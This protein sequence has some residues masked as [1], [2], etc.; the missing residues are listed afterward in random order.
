MKR[1]LCIGCMTA[2]MLF[3]TSCG[4]DTWNSGTIQETKVDVSTDETSYMVSDN[5]ETQLLTEKITDAVNDE[6]HDTKD[7]S[8][9]F[10]VDSDKDNT[11]SYHIT[12]LEINGNIYI[13]CEEV[14]WNKDIDVTYDLIGFGWTLV[15]PFGEFHDLNR[16]IDLDFKEQQETVFAVCFATTAYYQELGEMNFTEHVWEVADILQH[17]LYIQAVQE[18]YTW[19]SFDGEEPLQAEDALKQYNHAY[20]VYSNNTKDEKEEK[21]GQL[22]IYYQ[23]FRHV[24]FSGFYRAFE[25]I[26]IEVFPL[27]QNNEALGVYY[28][29]DPAAILFCTAEQIENIKEIMQGYETELGLVKYDEGL[30][31]E[32]KV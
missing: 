24:L 21:R 6:E 23:Q 4:N 13:E 5:S 7:S 17:P 3:M 15:Q 14:V 2:V 18:N 22:F 12:E 25:D 20:E 32:L 30:L 31:E 9:C 8:G 1:F 29:T 27:Y 26:G 19:K 16:A 11:E 28:L 10:S